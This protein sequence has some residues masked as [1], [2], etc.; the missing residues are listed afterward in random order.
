MSQFKIMTDNTHLSSSL[1]W[2]QISRNNFSASTQNEN[3]HSSCQN[4]RNISTRPSIESVL[5]VSLSL[6]V[7]YSQ[8]LI[9]PSSAC[10]SYA[11]FSWRTNT[12]YQSYPLSQPC[13]C[14]WVILRHGDV[15][16][17]YE[18]GHH[19][20]HLILSLEAAE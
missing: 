19:G 4:F 7:V 11:L 14:C 1:T 20:H 3:Q 18:S 16:S 8:I 13:L 12:D 15:A 17:C 9:V 2:T 5:T 10:S 6:N